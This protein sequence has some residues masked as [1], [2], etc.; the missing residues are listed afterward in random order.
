MV[1]FAGGIIIQS[2]FCHAKNTLMRTNPKIA[3]VIGQD[4]ADDV[5]GQSF[6]DAEAGEFAIV[7]TQQPAS[8]SADPNGA[9]II[10]QQRPD[11][12]CRFAVRRLKLGDGIAANVQK[13][14]VVT[15]HP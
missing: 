5:V 2:R 8:K 7:K 13:H 14:A 9:I 1:G 4:L 3:G 11:R 15:T 6:I 12:F 10:G